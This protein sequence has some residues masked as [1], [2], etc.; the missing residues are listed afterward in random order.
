MKKKASKIRISD[1][2]FRLVS[3]GRYEVTYTSPVTGKKFRNQTTD[4]MLIDETKNEDDPKIVNLNIL[5]RL[6]KR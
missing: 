2:K 5:K 6:C 3:Y 4:M 1:F